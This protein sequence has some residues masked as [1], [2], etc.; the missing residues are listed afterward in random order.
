MGAFCV[1]REGRS[2]WKGTTRRR[3]Q[4]MWPVQQEDVRRVLM[5]GGTWMDVEPG[6]WVDFGR[7][8]NEFRFTT[9][10]GREVKG[11]RDA[12]LVT[13]ALEPALV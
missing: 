12:V 5:T 8:W 2:Q 6:T 9:T 1:L 10:D 11:Q 7:P 3:R 4:R 13:Q